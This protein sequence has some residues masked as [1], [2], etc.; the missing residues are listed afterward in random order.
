MVL[1][2][3][4]AFKTSGVHRMNRARVRNCAGSSV[5]TLAIKNCVKKNNVSVEFVVKESVWGGLRALN[6]VHHVYYTS[7]DCGSGVVCPLL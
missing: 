4:V 5:V 1:W 6:Y 2:V 3:L 7:H